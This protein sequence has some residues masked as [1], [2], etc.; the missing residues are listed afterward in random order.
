MSGIAV[1]YTG[2]NTGAGVYPAKRQAPS[3]QSAGLQS[4]GL[5][6]AGRLV[7]TAL[8]LAMG[9]GAGSLRAENAVELLPPPEGARQLDPQQ[10]VWVDPAKSRVYVD[11][12]VVLR[13]GVL[14]MFACPKGTKEH[15]SVVAVDAPAY[16]VHTALLAVGAEEGSPV[17]FDPKYQPPTGTVIEVQVQ[18]T[19]DGKQQTAK[20]QDWVRDANT[21]RAM[22]LPWVFAGSGFWTDPDSGKQVYLADAGDFI[23][24][25]N[26]GAAMLDVPAPSSAANGELWFEPFTER[27]PPRGTPVRLI[28]TPQPDAKAAA[29]A[30]PAETSDD[31]LEKAIAALHAARVGEGSTAARRAAWETV[32]ATPPAQLPTVLRAMKDASPLAENWLRTAVDAIADRAGPTALPMGALR[33]FVAETSNAPRARRVAYELIRRADPALADSMLDALRDDPSSEIRYDAV[34]KTLAQA[35]AAPEADRAPLYRTA[36]Q[37]ART[38]DQI[39]AA[40]RGLESLGEKVKLVDELGF[41]TDWSV[42]GPFDNRGGAGFDQP[43]PPEASLDAAAEYSGHSADG[44]AGPFGW[45]TAESAD[46]LG[47]VDLNDALGRHKGAVGYLWAT[48]ESD[49]ER[50]V[51]IRY[52]S[53]VATKVWVNGDLV[54]EHETYHSGAPFDQYVAQAKLRRGVNQLL[55]KACQNEQTDS[56]AEAWP[57]Q[58]RLTGPDAEPLEGVTSHPGANSN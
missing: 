8:G 2:A 58:L 50:D 6:S 30:A 14:E 18:W 55:V 17:R 13:E 25:S 24:V 49:T 44:P 47:E 7:V 46:R 53:I 35:D 54:A 26:F 28:L 33:E 38:L 5:Q 48:V 19:K 4:A 29:D 21:G 51:E 42:A 12:H 10:P 34:A 41:V 37:S 3:L 20:A 23:C 43:Y 11:G 1:S 45:K 57:I 22:D 36:L 9:L 31:N 56:W 27:I 39:E 40:E 32:A 16:L 15:E 52:S